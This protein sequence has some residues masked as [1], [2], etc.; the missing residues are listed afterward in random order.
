MVVKKVL[1]SF[2]NSRSKFN[3][4]HLAIQVSH[5]HYIYITLRPFQS[6]QMV[7]L[8]CKEIMPT[9]EMRINT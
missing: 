6:C 1:T 9:K 5:G 7:P 3:K 4:K 2:K 8:R